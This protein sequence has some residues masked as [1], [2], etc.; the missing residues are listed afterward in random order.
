MLAV[1]TAPTPD[2]Y[3]S[4]IDGPMSDPTSAIA[5]AGG[6]AA[7][8]AI[9]SVIGFIIVL[10]LALYLFTSYC[11][12]RIAKKANVEDA[13]MSWIPI[14][15]LIVMIRLAQKPL[16]W[17]IFFIIPVVNAVIAIVLWMNIF[18]RFG[19]PEWMGLLM[20]IPVVNL[21]MLVYLAFS[22]TAVIGHY[23]PQPAGNGQASPLPPTPIVNKEEPPVKP[24]V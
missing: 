23:S 21:A 12:Y 2:Y 4:A 16:W 3:Q 11:L 19:K 17:I 9:L 8:V 5:A 6:A 10:G 1:L 14:V 15:S 13:W 24:T 20:I 22:E 7:S 18:P